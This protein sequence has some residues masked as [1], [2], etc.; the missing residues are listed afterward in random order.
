[1]AAYTQAGAVVQAFTTITTEAT[2]DARDP[3]LTL[4]AEGRLAMSYFVWD[5]A[6]EGAVLDGMRVM[7]SPENG[8]TWG[9]P[10]TIDSAFTTWAA[11][12]GT[13]V[14]L[15]N[16]HLLIPTYGVSA[17]QPFQHA[18]VSRSTDGGVIWAPLAVIANGNTQGGRHYQ[19]PNIILTDKGDLLAVIR[20]DTTLTHFTS[21]S[22]AG[23]ATWSTPVSAF[24]G[25]GAPR[26]TKQAG[27][28]HCL[29]RHESTGRAVKISSGDKGVT[30]SNQIV[31]PVFGAKVSSAHGVAMPLG[32]DSLRYVYSLQEGANNVATADILL[33]D[34]IVPEDRIAPGP[35]GCRRRNSASV[36]V[37]SATW[38]SI[39]FSIEDFDKGSLHSLTT[40]TNRISIPAGLEGYYNIVGTVYL[41]ASTAVQVQAR[42][43]R[44]GAALPGAR[45]KK[46][47]VSG[48]DAMLTAVN[49]PFYL[50]A[51]DYLELQAYQDSGSAVSAR[52]EDTVFSAVMVNAPV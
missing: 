1:M 6:A 52:S 49:G 27:Y 4:L 2:Y 22:R 45:D 17:G 40:N 18:A 34:A 41:A 12:A 11:G 20:S 3:R 23:G 24:A 39:T 19:E 15:P 16:G 13:I 8:V 37:N 33:V 30:L 7:F 38:T 25:N 35:V 46:N 42:I 48:H 10:V 14:E 9:A 26:L 50:G 29:H 36:Q 32:K 31:L 5:V 21:R 44:N 51:G 43:L 28:I 47:P